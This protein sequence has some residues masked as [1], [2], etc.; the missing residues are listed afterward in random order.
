MKTI[1][2]IT[3]AGVRPRELVLWFGTFRDGLPEG[4]GSRLKEEHKQ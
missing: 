1:R 3:M 2:I 4:E